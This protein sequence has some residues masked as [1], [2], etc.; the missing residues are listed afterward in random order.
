MKHGSNSMA[1]YSKGVND[2]FAA[3]KIVFNNGTASKVWQSHRYTF[4][5]QTFE[6]VIAFYRQV[7]NLSAISWQEQVNFLLR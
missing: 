4:N 3:V 6:R 2:L 7:S 5:S 1:N